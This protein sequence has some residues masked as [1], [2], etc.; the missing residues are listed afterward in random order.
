M[1][2]MVQPPIPP[3]ESGTPE[4]LD[5][6]DGGLRSAAL[7]SPANGEH[8]PLVP[9]EARVDVPSEAAQQPEPE[10]RPEEAADTQDEPSEDEAAALLAASE[11]SN[12]TLAVDTPPAPLAVE[13]SL[14]EDDG[15]ASEPDA[16]ASDSHDDPLDQGI[17]AVFAR[18]MAATLKPIRAG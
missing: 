12:E 4:G 11:E 17:A 14:P 9:E 6:G 1:K 7:H 10:Q 8:E 5:H 16:P 3:N 15:G 13:E 18:P 2:I